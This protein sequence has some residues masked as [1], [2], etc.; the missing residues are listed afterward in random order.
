MEKLSDLLINEFGEL[1]LYAYDSRLEEIITTPVYGVHRTDGFTRMWI[2][3][4]VKINPPN[5]DL[6]TDPS[7]FDF[8][9]F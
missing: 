7:P 5:I 1:E 4:T 3:N 9:S 6:D 2:W 8:D